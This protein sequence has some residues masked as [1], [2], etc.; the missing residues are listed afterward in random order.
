MYTL[1][2]KAQALIDAAVASGLPPVYT[3]P[4][5]EARARM[6]AAFIQG[7]P[8]SIALIE[9]HVIPGPQ[10]G[11]PVRLYHPDPGS[12]LPLVLFYH[13]GGW[14]VNDLDT[15]DRLATLIAKDSGCAVL[16]VEYRVCPESKY[17]APVE[18]AY[19]SF[20]WAHD[21]GRRL[22]ADTSRICVAGDSSGGT[23]AT[24]VALL[25]RDRNGP[26]ILLQVL[27]Y[28]VTDY[29]EPQNQSYVER[30]TGY[31]LNYDFMAWSWRN[32]LPETWF[33]RRSVS[34]PASRGRSGRAAECSYPNRRI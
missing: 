23:L 28:P 5:N 19:T 14:T 7:E 10:G 6:R 34:I 20:I 13:G 25:A 1:D 31:S 3:L 32:Y 24:V 17:P 15:H 22:H 2:P 8:E 27:F 30:G 11:I 9:N 18:D 29:L 26:S 16:S 12:D 21:N 33:S 4:N